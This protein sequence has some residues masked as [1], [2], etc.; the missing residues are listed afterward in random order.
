M[1]NNYDQSDSPQARVPRHGAGAGG[2]PTRFPDPNLPPTPTQALSAGLGTLSTSL[3]SLGG[4]VGGT[5]GLAGLLAG[6][7]ASIGAAGADMGQI[8]QPTPTQMNPG[9]APTSSD[10]PGLPNNFLGSAAGGGLQLAADN[11][12][13]QSLLLNRSLGAGANQPPPPFTPPPGTMY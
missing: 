9:P 7:G 6:A 10:M 2:G 12:T 1:I 3:G 8:G 5:P 13:L 4:S 11:P